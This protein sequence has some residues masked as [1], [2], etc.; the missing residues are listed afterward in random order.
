[1]IGMILAETEQQ[2]RDASKLV[3]IK[4][5][6]LPAVFTIEVFIFN[7]GCNGKEILF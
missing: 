2:A 4:Y 5:Q 1:M 3:K 7:I 6:A